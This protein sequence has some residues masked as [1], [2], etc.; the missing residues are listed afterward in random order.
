MAVIEEARSSSP[1][2]TT[3]GKEDPKVHIGQPL[4]CKRFEDGSAH[5]RT[6]ILLDE[7]VAISDHGKRSVRYTS[8]LLGTPEYVDEISRLFIPLMLHF[9]CLSVSPRHLVRGLL[10]CASSDVVERLVV[11]LVDAIPTCAGDVLDALCE[12]A[13][14]LPLPTL[15]LLTAVAGVR[16]D[17]AALACSTPRRV[18]V[19]EYLC[20]WRVHP[21]LAL[22]VSCG[23]GDAVPFVL[24]CLSSSR[25]TAWIAPALARETH[26]VHK[27]TLEQIEQADTPAK[28][29]A[30]LRL[31]CLMSG[32][33]NVQPGVA[34]AKALLSL[35]R[36]STHKRVALVGVAWL[37]CCKGLERCVTQEDISE[38][39]G[40]VANVGRVR[41]TLLQVSLMV[42]ARKDEDAVR[43]ILECAR[44]PHHVAP[45][46]LGLVRTALLHIIDE[47]HVGRHALTMPPSPT[48]LALLHRL[49]DTDGFVRSG[50]DPCP[51]MLRL[52]GCAR[53]PIPP[54]FPGVLDR[55]VS[56]IVPSNP[57][58]PHTPHPPMRAVMDA[59]HRPTRSP[60]HM[61]MAYFVLAHQRACD[62]H[63]VNGPYH[64]VAGDVGLAARVLQVLH[65]PHAQCY[66]PLYPALLALVHT[67]H[68][69]LFTP[70][71]GLLQ[72]HAKNTQQTTHTTAF[73]SNHA[74]PI[75][76]VRNAF[77]NASTNSSLAA[78]VLRWMSRQPLEVLRDY[79]GVLGG[80]VLRIA[81]G[82]SPPHRLARLYSHVW[83]RMYASC[84]TL[85]V[86]TLSELL[87]ESLG[88]DALAR[89]PLVVLRAKTHHLVSP[90]TLG[91]CL[92]VLQRAL[93]SSRRLLDTS[94]ASMQGEA[95]SLRLLQEC[96][97]VQMLLEVCCASPGNDAPRGD[98]SLHITRGQRAEV[99]RRVCEF[100][101]QLFIETPLLVKL[102]HFQGYPMEIVP[103]TTKRIPSM[104]VCLEFLPE[105][106]AQGERGQLMAIHLAAHL[107]SSFPI[108]KSLEMA[109]LMI[110]HVKQ[111]WRVTLTDKLPMMLDGL[112]LL[113]KAFP[114][115]LVEEVIELMHGLLQPR[116]ASRSIGHSAV[117]GNS[118]VRMC[119][120]SAIRRL[121]T[122]RKTDAW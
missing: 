9:G 44:V 112:V 56:S 119:V 63:H 24:G 88:A 115:Y 67:R 79:H 111:A 104:H 47:R 102:V 107:A 74:L 19:R 3:S 78:I 39:L 105:L 121:S 23:I 101:H 114:S 21:S 122:M 83:Q 27:H 41:D 96:A 38:C 32:L 61:L 16:E 55:W 48:L 20:R 29:A 93:V 70:D 64:S 6:R 109:K 7:L 75:C 92:L 91:L 34:H 118:R 37:L 52:I 89:D 49:L 85:G 73:P 82:K 58:A 69:A 100:I 28:Q 12:E 110:R 4:L 26:A 87:G 103:L 65:G 30:I 84:E 94:P 72:E 36:N 2:G 116:L 5:V 31:F 117:Q 108:P 22:D 77:A 17:A 90:E 35:T 54:L 51:C 60:Q 59:L 62:V 33:A 40:D 76:F 57:E 43:T 95:R 14:S 13:E 45:H 86:C 42:H 25:C 99:Q 80:P 81:T 98:Q 66:A 50:A 46:S 11:V 8:A 18:L 1:D 120:L 15:A 53:V 113:A 68:P 71:A 97:V 106:L 10:G